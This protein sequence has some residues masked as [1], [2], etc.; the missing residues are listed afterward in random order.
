[1]ITLGYAAFALAAAIALMY[2]VQ[3]HQLKTRRLGNSFM[4]L[5]PILRLESVQGWLVVAGFLLLT[6]GLISGFLGF[7]A[8]R[9][10]LSPDSKLFWSMGVWFMYFIWVVG[11]Y[12]WGL[13]GRR[14]AWLTVG[15]C[16]FVF[17]TFW[18]SNAFSQFHRY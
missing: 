3:E 9:L 17:S 15:G 10:T 2:L 8:T 13:G 14:M 12:F 4:V 18:L 11:R 1:V 7:H 5:P 16:I 6:I